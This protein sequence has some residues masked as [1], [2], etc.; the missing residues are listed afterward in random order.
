MDLKPPLTI[1]E[2]IERLKTHNLVIE[3]EE[4]AKKFLTRNNY[5]RF[6]GYALQYRIAPHDSTLRNGISFNHLAQIYCFDE[7]LRALLRTFI[8]KTE[9]YYRTVIAYRFSLHR[10]INEPH[11]QHYNIDNFENVERF[12]EIKK[13]FTK[14]RE[15]Y[16][17]SLIVKH[18]SKKYA[19]K[20]P[21]WVIVELL[22]YSDL[23]KFYSCM[24]KE[25]QDLIAKAVG[26]TADFLKNHLHCLA[27]LR[28]KCAHAGRLYNEI[29]NPPAKQ[30]TNF[31]KNNPSVQTNSLF[32]YIFM[33]YKRLPSTDDK[34]AFKLS[35]SLLIEKHSKDLDLELMGFPLNWKNIMGI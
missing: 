17:D 24:L 7:E 23:S 9:V 34:K 12:N 15:Y 32:S 35:L 13:N 1:E 14:E 3:D 29:I 31:M 11:N 10:C 30:T 22:S 26:T 27:V 33:L 18:H 20:M 16:N 25:D 8:E 6:T 19:D 2:Q 5:Y 4:L 21:L 28:N